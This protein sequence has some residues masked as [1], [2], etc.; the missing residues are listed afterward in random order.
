VNLL[1]R[2]PL[3]VSAHVVKQRALVAFQRQDVVAALIDDLPG[4]LALAVERVGSHGGAPRLRRGRL[5]RGRP[6]SVSI[7]SSFGTAVISTL[8]GA[9]LAL[10]LLAVTGQ[11]Q[12]APQN[13]G[14][15]I[16]VP[17]GATL[18][19]LPGPGAVAA[20]NT[21]NAGASEPMP[22]MQMIAQQRAAM[23]HM[24]ANMNA[25]FPP[26]PDPNTMLR[27]AFGAGGPFNVSIMPL[28][29]GHGVCSQS[30]SIIAR[31]DGSAP[32][33][34]IS[35]SGDACGPLGVSKPQG[36]DE[37]R[38]E[39]P[40]PPAQG[41]KLLDIGYPPHPVTNGTPPRT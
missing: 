14:R 3:E 15:V 4:D 34:K 28:A 29:G 11:A 7:S 27:A 40:T 32:I 26:L 39:T 35:Q 23:Q 18:V 33:V 16:Y 31:G 8:L 10:P 30:I 1:R 19:I 20:P 13:G 25:M 37:D 22:L 5:R 2:D 38:P 9:C 36:V 41:P 17:P 21:V 12:P 6:L 24:I